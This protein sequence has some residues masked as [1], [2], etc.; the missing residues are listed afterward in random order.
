MH[1]GGGVF[2]QRIEFHTDS[3]FS[4]YHEAV[5]RAKKRKH[6]SVPKRQL[7]QETTT[8]G[9]AAS[10]VPASNTAVAPTNCSFLSSPEG[11]QAQPATPHYFSPAGSSANFFSSLSSPE[12]RQA[13]SATSRMFLPAGSSTLDQPTANFSTPLHRLHHRPLNSQNQLSLLHSILTQTLSNT[14]M[15]TQTV[16]QTPA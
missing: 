15:T 12:S 6:P 2:F 8:S 13:Q 9:Q 3:D 10:A 14:F 1:G 11:R 5:R 4:P 16:S 7:F